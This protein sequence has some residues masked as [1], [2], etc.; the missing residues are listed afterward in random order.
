MAVVDQGSAAEAPEVCDEDQA[1][2][3]DAPQMEEEAANAQ[4]GQNA[5]A[6]E[7]QN[8]IQNTLNE[9]LLPPDGAAA[10]SSGGRRLKRRTSE[11]GEAAQGSGGSGRSMD[12]QTCTW[13]NRALMDTFNTFGQHVQA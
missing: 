8:A 7:M 12:A 3:A 13:L 2:E 10:S 1:M 4:D 5:D 9:W 11:E 6:S